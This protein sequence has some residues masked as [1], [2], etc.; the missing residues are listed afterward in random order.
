[1][2]KY[3]NIYIL[4]WRQ[5]VNHFTFSFLSEKGLTLILPY[6]SESL[7]GE[8]LKIFQ[9]FTKNMWLMTLLTLLFVS[10][11][12]WFVE[13]RSIG[14]ISADS[15]SVEEAEEYA[16]EYE[17]KSNDAVG[18]MTMASFTKLFPSTASNS[19]LTLTAHSMASVES[20]SA[21]LFHLIWCLFALIWCSCYTANLAA[22]LSE[23]K[24]TFAATSF[25]EMISK[26]AT[27][28]LGPV[29]GFAGIINKINVFAFYCSKKKNIN[30]YN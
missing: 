26:Q 15:F 5:E 28:E 9:P 21:I 13:H 6:Y 18:Y 3:D 29:C 19:F 16:K 4:D 17:Q 27:G 1:M 24:Y 10:L 2:I 8:T 7:L 20:L 25:D 14:E 23:N 12:T 22:I 11:V 30:I